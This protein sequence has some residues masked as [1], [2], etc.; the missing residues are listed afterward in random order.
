VPQGAQ[1]RGFVDQA[2]SG[3]VDQPG[4]GLHG[5]QRPLIDDGLRSRDDGYGKDSVVARGEQFEQPGRRQD[6]VGLGWRGEWLLVDIS[7]S[8]HSALEPHDP[9][10]RVAQLSTLQRLPRALA[11]ELDQLG[12]PSTDREHHHQHV[13]GDGSAED[14]APV[15][16]NNPAR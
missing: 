4:P 13:L 2:A 1:Q 5:G 8:G 14:A 12:K 6:E 11:L 7:G 10:R 15:R 3:N 16:H 9:N